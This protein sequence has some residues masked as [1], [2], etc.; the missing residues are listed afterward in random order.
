[1]KKMG[2]KQPPMPIQTDN[3]TALGVVTNN[4]QP[5]CT[6]AMDMR[7]HWLCD[8]KTQDQFKYYWRPG[9]T[10][11]ADYWTKHNCAAHHIKKRPEILTLLLIQEELHAST[12]QAPAKS[13]KGLLQPSQ[14]WIITAR[15]G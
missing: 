10:N 8:R 7:C 4:I 2:H 14:A 9:P 6:K 11:H 3:S 5:H 13:R 15:A 1:M 12:K